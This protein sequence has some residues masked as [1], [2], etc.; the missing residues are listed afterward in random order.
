MGG[1][2][3]ASHSS[4]WITAGVAKSMVWTIL[5]GIVHTKDP[6]LLIGNN[7][8]CSSG[9]GFLLLLYEWSFM[10]LPMPYKFNRK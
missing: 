3:A 10:I 6:L 9:R 8:P 2:L 5:S 7:S 4:E 1:P